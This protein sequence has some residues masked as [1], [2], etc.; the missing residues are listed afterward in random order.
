MG[1]IHVLLRM[2]CLRVEVCV[3]SNVN[4][5]DTVGTLKQIAAE[6][7][8]PVWIPSLQRVLQSMEVIDP[9]EARNAQTSRSHKNQ[10]GHEAKG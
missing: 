7:T 4:D 8:S 1:R 5:L 10:N 3:L 6:G 2:G 9:Q